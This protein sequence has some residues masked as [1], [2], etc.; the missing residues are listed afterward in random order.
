[1]L[2]IYCLLGISVFCL[3]YQDVKEQ[4]ISLPGLLGFVIAT[5]I[6]QGLEPNLESVWA[7]CMIAFI[8]M[9]C[10]GIFYLVRREFVMGWGDLILCPFCGLWLGFDELPLFFVATGAF[11]LIIGI[12]WYFRWKM[13]MFP[14]VPALL[15]GLGVVFLNRCFSNAIGV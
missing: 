4:T 15:L 9:S 2:L 7:A 13:R 14:F 5:L 1:M 12:F 11:A 8:F 6:H 3:V 10:Q